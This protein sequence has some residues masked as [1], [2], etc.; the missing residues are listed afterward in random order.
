MTQEV[1]EKIYNHVVN[2]LY[3]PAFGLRIKYTSENATREID[4]ALNLQ[5]YE[6]M[7]SDKV[8]EKAI[9]DRII[10]QGVKL[11]QSFQNTITAENLESFLTLSVLDRM[12]RDA[13]N[14]I[15]AEEEAKK[16]SMNQQL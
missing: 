10:A 11:A 2:S 13:F 8:Q 6:Y 14:A 9:V 5:V 16:E 15:R 12:A 1:Y 4:E 3:D 7:V